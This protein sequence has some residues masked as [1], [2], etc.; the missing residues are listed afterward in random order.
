M[1]YR[2]LQAYRLAISS[3]VKEH[4]SAW[5]SNTSKSL[6]QF[7]GTGARLSTKDISEKAFGVHPDQYVVSPANLSED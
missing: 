1:R 5:L 2:P 4:S 6:T 7:P 3:E